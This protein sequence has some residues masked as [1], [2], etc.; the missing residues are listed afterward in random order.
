MADDQLVPLEGACSI[1]PGLEES[2]CLDDTVHNTP[3]EIETDTDTIENVSLSE[4]D[5]DMQSEDKDAVGGILAVIPA[6]PKQ[7]GRLVGNA[8][9]VVTFQDED[10]SYIVQ[11]CGGHA[12]AQAPSPTLDAPVTRGLHERE[13][14][15]DDDLYPGTEI[16]AGDAGICVFSDRPRVEAEGSMSQTSGDVGD[17]QEDGDVSLDARVGS[18]TEI[19]DTSGHLQEENTEQSGNV[20]Q[21]GDNSS[22]NDQ[23]TA[24]S[25]PMQMLQD[26]HGFE[27]QA[28][29]SP[30]SKP[31]L[32][33]YFSKSDSVVTPRHPTLES[34]QSVLSEVNPEGEKSVSDFFRMPQNATDDTEGLAFFDSAAA[35]DVRERRRTLSQTS[36]GSGF[37][38]P[39]PAETSAT[40]LN[41]MAT[42][43]EV[44]RS[45]DAWIPSEQTRQTLVAMAT[46]LPGSY[47][48]DQ[49]SLTMPGVIVE[50]LMGDPVRDLVERFMGEHEAVKRTSLIQDRLTADVD[51]LV[52]LI[53]RG[54]YRAAVDLTAQLLATHGQGPGKSG[55]LTT[56]TP[57]TLQLWF[58]RMALLM[59][60]GQYNSAEVEI[61]SFGDMDRP[62]IYYDYYQDAYNCR[63]GSIVP[64]SLRLLHAQLPQYVHKPQDSLDRL[65]AMHAVVKKI[66]KN[67]AAGFSEDGS[68]CELSVDSRKASEDLWAG[69][70]VRL[71]YSIAH[72]LLAVKDY[73]LAIQVY[74][75]LVAR[76]S[77]HAVKLWGGIGRLYLIGCL[78]NAEES[79]D[80]ADAQDKDPTPSS[81]CGRLMNRAYMQV[82]HNSFSEALWL[83]REA[84]QADANNIS[85]V[86]NVAVC[87]LYLGRLKEAIATLEELVHCNPAV[88][89]HEG[90]VFN[91]CTL[92]ELES[93][94][95]LT[96]KQ[97]L[98][99]LVSKHQG[100]GFAISSLKMA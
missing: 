23:D 29:G 70:E 68:Q 81:R 71:L 90:A 99:D 95:A 67:L 43:S 75:Q 18:N 47:F 86:N 64:F 78:A 58:L 21:S 27:S 32:C 37:S 30:A 79:F 2:I 36:T 85:A 7:V 87:L 74:E 15:D 55:H 76:D 97:A 19:D 84:A 5:G 96:K 48:P 34:Q 25:L 82:A 46:S 1:V 61:E 17:D 63:R 69:R 22:E 13:E 10:I 93:S 56:N 83:F 49:D 3:V 50:D 9:E 33:K 59:R 52:Q 11:P 92:Y 88:N 80:L 53:N 91:L 89:T 54:N 8:P 12:S 16:V 6:L 31:D 38:P 98:L 4:N 100:D 44:D 60:L 26:D 20:E 72:A 41:S 42:V 77:E 40:W 62:D 39:M 24:R 57:D 51:G 66:G 73:N 28:I 14:E 35:D 94:R 65:Y 45:Q